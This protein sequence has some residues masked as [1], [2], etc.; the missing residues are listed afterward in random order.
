MCSKEEM[1]WYFSKFLECFQAYQEDNRKIFNDFSR[2]LE[3]LEHVTQGK[4]Q[5]F[6]VQVE[7]LR[8]DMTHMSRNLTFTDTCELLVTGVPSNS[9]VNAQNVAEVVLDALETPQLKNFVIDSREWLP[10]QR[11]VN[12]ISRGD[13][14][15]TR[16]FVFK[17]ASPTVR[18]SIISRSKKLRDRDSQSLFN[19]GGKSKISIRPLYPKP[20]S[21]LLRTAV[22]KCEALNYARPVVKSFTVCIRETLDSQL[23]PIHCQEDLDAFKPREPPPILATPAS[24]KNPSQPIQQRKQ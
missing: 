23:I 17:L 18:D 16:G 20:V 21:E 14:Q 5:E 10:G 12:S 11:S 4:L 1:P 9:S 13:S 8:E 6:S 22:K 3:A 24:P 7:H 2:R 19:C 15:S